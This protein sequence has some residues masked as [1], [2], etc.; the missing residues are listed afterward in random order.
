MLW[1]QL[2]VLLLLARGLGALGRRIGQPPIVGSLLAG[3]LAGPSVFGQVWP[4]GFHWFLPGG[5]AHSGPLEAIAGFSLLILLIS[6]GAET[7]LPLIRALGR[8]AAWIITTSIALPLAAGLAVGWLLPAT[9]MGDSPHRVGFAL[10]IAGAISVSSLPVV[11]RIVTE[12]GIVRRDVGQVTVA[13][14]T[15]NDA[16]G[17]ALLAILLAVSAGHGGAHLAVAI[18]ALVALVP[19]VATVGQWTVDRALRE[20]RRLGPDQAGAVGV[21]VVATLALAAICQ[22]LGLDAALGAFVAG[23]V[24]GRSRF[25]LGQA[26]TSIESANDAVFAPLYFATAGLSVNVTLLGDPTTAA[27]F[28]IVLAVALVAKFAA[29]HLGGLLAR[30][31]RREA[32]ALGIALNGRGAMQVIFGAAGLA[33]GLLSPAAYTIVIL[34]SIVS[35]ML[36]PPLLRRT[37][38]EWEGTTEEQQRL[39]HEK[40]MQTNVVVRGQRLLL[41]TRGSA[42]SFAAAR[43]L[44]LAWPATSEVT[45]LSIVAADAEDPDLEPARRVLGERTVREQ[46]VTGDDVVEA[47]LAEANLGYGVIAVG[48]VDRPTHD[49][50]LPPFVQELLN[51][52]PIPLVVVRRGN[53]DR[54]DADG[55]PMLRPRRIVVPVTGNAASRAGEEVA[56][57]ISRN[58][59]AEV[60]L[61]HVLT[62]PSRNARPGTRWRRG[63]AAPAPPHAGTAVLDQARATLAEQDLDADVVLRHGSSAGEEIHRQTQSW[64]ADLIVV[65]SAVRRVGGRPFLGHTVEHLLEHATETTV[66]AVVLPDAQVASREE[67]VDRSEG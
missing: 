64:S 32:T 41:P 50:V 9:L 63:R 13:T 66:V 34:M 10:L 26:V 15:A 52:V 59:G 31:P 42:N 60:T 36:V 27:A 43:I 21:A 19:V 58:C 65:G 7:D 4:H 11:A 56:T 47:I 20:T 46:R 55:R 14:A 53:V 8:P 39:R 5:Q 3:L 61:V 48:A 30:L 6:L 17:F 54:T 35:S 45:L 62:R 49:E 16:Y 1:T 12:M 28:G 22:A 23:V 57:A 37:L 2:A 44:D 18:G 51:R 33:A 38:H 29:A 25:M 24:V 67:H 40:Q